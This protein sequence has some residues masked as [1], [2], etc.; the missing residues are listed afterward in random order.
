MSCDPLYLPF[1]AAAT[2]LK[3]RRRPGLLW[4]PEASQ[5]WYVFVW[6]QAAYAHNCPL[7]SSADA[8]LSYEFSD[9]FYCMSTH[10]FLLNVCT[11]RLMPCTIYATSL[12]YSNWQLEAI[13]L[14]LIL[15]TFLFPIVETDIW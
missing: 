7:G 13:L 3:E 1:A 8:D 9:I 11:E 12:F 5:S 10:C 15:V 6:P 14:I 2:R 4:R